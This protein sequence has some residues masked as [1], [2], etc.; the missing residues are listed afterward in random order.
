MFNTLPGDTSDI[1]ITSGKSLNYKFTNLKPSTEYKFYV[2]AE[3]E[4]GRGMVSDL[5]WAQT[6]DNSW[7][8]PGPPRNFQAIAVSDSSIR[9]TWTVPA[10]G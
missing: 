4:Y 3:N 10:T 9:I 8:V 5:A 2:L 6:R 1:K 7:A